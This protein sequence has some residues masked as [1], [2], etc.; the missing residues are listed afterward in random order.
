[1]REEKQDGIPSPEN[2]Q[3]QYIR[4]KPTSVPQGSPVPLAVHPLVALHQEA[5]E[6]CWAVSVPSGAFQ[7]E[8]NEAVFLVG[9]SRQ[10]H[11]EKKDAFDKNNI[12]KDRDSYHSVQPAMTSGN[13]R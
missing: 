4:D 5:S 2:A 3:L 10:I 1:M 9:P 6:S 13:K 7:W 8:S 11:R 12:N